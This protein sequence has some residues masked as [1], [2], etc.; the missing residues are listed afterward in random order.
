ML[1]RPCGRIF[2][3]VADVA[4]GFRIHQPICCCAPPRLILLEGFCLQLRHILVRPPDRPCTEVKVRVFDFGVHP[5]VTFDTLLYALWD[6]IPHLRL[7]L[8]LYVETEGL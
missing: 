6:E 2:V 1:P 8:F 3:T 5:E 4:E 7:Q